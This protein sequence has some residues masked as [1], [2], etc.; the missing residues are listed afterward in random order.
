MADLGFNPNIPNAGFQAGQAMH[1]QGA[2]SGMLQDLVKMWQE[3]RGKK[4]D[5]SQ[6]KEL[7]D[8]ESTAG[9]KKLAFGEMIKQAYDNP[10]EYDT[11][12]QSAVNSIGQTTDEDTKIKIYQRIAGKYP[13]KSS[14]L[15][16]I[17]LPKSSTSNSEL[18]D[19]INSMQ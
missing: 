16:R 9:I 1:V 8:Y 14:D 12:L 2:G 3:D 15:K 13:K 10:P 18:M 11:D 19:I 17:L 6:R 5:M 4:Q 7:I